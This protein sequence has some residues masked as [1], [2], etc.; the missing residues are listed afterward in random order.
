MSYGLL[1]GTSKPS[2]ET[3]N[4]T[5]GSVLQPMHVITPGE[6]CL[7]SK[8]QVHPAHG[9]D[10]NVGSPPVTWSTT[11]RKRAGLKSSVLAV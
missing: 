9:C 4:S 2:S 10:L 5:T 6:L 8:T 3:L 1:Q 11:A 7:G